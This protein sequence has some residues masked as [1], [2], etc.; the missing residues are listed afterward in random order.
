MPSKKTGS[1][2]TRRPLPAAKLPKGGRSGDSFFMRRC[3][4]L[5]AKG[6]GKVS[7]NPLVG[8]AVVRNGKIIGEGHHKEFGSAHAE[9]DAFADAE[10][11]FAARAASKRASLSR[12]CDGATL[13][14]S[15]EPCSH[16]GG[17]KKTPPCAP[18]VISSGVSRVVIATKDPN[19]C[20]SGEGI[21]QLRAAGIRVDVGILQS[22][23]QGQNA[24]F[25][26]FM[27]TGKPFIL[28]KLAQSKNGKI[29]IQ[30]KGKVQIS[31]KQFDAY[32]HLLRN[33]YDAIL[34]G[35]N[36]VL[37]DNPR[38]TCRMKGGRNPVR[39]ILD[40]NLRIPLSSR[41]LHN[42]KK[43][44]VLIFTTE[45]RGRAKEKALCKLGAEV[46]LCGKTKVDLKR[47]AA[48]LPAYGI[49]SVLVEGGA[50]TIDSFI[51]AKLADRL[52]L[53]I[54]PKEISGANAVASPITPAMLR[55]LKGAKRERMGGDQVMSGKFA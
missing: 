29:G 19:P 22:E 48:L 35:A 26:K 49:F 28:A 6:E 3:L 54:S 36:T 23:A 38:L 51:R 34:V 43:G 44:R 31:G 53:A 55:R 7:P 16:C 37:A 50:Q 40:S 8:A 5:A 20:V 42:A 11:R 27:R 18:L 30:G 21:A 41:V 46:I 47:L 52:V 25:F 17:C 9:V 13:Y 24:P 1:F 33:R 10:K 2:S 12:P 4:S 32:C 15:L 14:V 39:I 45:K